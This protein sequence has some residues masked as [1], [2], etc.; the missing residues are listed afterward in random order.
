MAVLV[1]GGY[2]LIGSAVVARL[3]DRPVVG[4]G[5]DVAV[6]RRRWPGVVWREADLAQLLRAEDWTP[7]LAGVES[8]VNA[9]GVLQQGLRDDVAGVQE[10]AMLALYAAARQTGIKRIVQI[11]AVGAEPRAST[12]FL[13]SKARADDALRASG[14]DYVILRPGLVIS[15]AAY[16]GTALIRGLAAFPALLP[17]VLADSRVQT[18][19]VEDVAEAVARALDSAPSGTI[20]DLVERPIHSLAEIVTRFR[21]WLGLGAAPVVRL[22]DLIGRLA[23]ASSDLLGWLG[24]RSPLRSTALAVMREGVLGDPVPGP[25]LLGRELRTLPQTLAALPAGPQ[26]LWFARLWLAKPLI[27]GVLSVFWIASGAVTLG[28]LDGAVSVLTSRG[29]PTALAWAITFGGGVTDIALGLLLLMRPLAGVALK[30]MIAL[31][32][33][34][35]AGSLVFA[36]DLWLDP[37]GPMVKAIPTL[38]L[39]LVALAILDER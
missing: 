8:V 22:P 33:A 11:S 2:G 18:V 14:L 37:L 7:L 25:M 23:A 27:L 16:G 31:T 5:R 4:L 20:V 17:L 30:G 6:S 9:A 32:L 1:L 10:R 36:P 24:W 28:R 3:C 12:E 34:Y 38:V 15:S 39:A 19:C 29:S 21:A 13:R 26:E 35:L